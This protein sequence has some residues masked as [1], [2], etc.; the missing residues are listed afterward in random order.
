MIKLKKI[1][2]FLTLKVFTNFYFVTKMLV[3]QLC[4][5]VL[6]DDKI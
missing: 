2:L 3:I 5:H 4:D 1:N 6:V